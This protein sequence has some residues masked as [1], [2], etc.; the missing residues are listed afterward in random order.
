MSMGIDDGFWAGVGATVLVVVAGLVTYKIIKKKKPEAIEK[1]RKS[2]AN[3]GRKTVEIAKGAREAFRE[4]Y[5]GAKATA[6]GDSAEAAP[7]TA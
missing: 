1:A 4:G 5:E 3:L 6:A 7:A 2:A